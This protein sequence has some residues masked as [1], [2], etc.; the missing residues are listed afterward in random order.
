MTGSVELEILEK[1]LVL[2]K[3]N[4]RRLNKNIKLTMWKIKNAKSKENNKNMVSLSEFLTEEPNI[5]SWCGEEPEV[6]FG[7]LC[8]GCNREFD[9]SLVKN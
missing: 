7:S 8:Y 9:L 4:R 3:S 1:Q 5:C 2:L 6:L